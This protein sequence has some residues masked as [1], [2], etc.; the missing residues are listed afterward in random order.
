MMVGIF[1]AL[2]VEQAFRLDFVFRLNFIRSRDDPMQEAR[3]HRGCNS[4]Q[5]HR[6]DK[7]LPEFDRGADPWV[8][9]QAC[10]ESRRVGMLQDIHYMRA[11][12]ARWIVQS[13]IGKAT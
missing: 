13:G 9:R 8:L 7:T 6:L 5:S 3:D 2:R 1:P 11:A 12:D 10:I 4:S